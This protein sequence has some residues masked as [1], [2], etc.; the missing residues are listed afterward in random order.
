MNKSF[1][2]RI[3]LLSIGAMLAG[4]I[5]CKGPASLNTDKP[6]QNAQNPAGNGSGGT[7]NPSNPVIPKTDQEK[8]EAA[9]AALEL[10]STEKV[11]GW[12]NLPRNGRYDTSISWSA[13]PTGIIDTD[14][15]SSDR[16][17]IAQPEE[18]TQ[19]T[20]TA[21]ITKGSASA[22]KTFTVT[23]YGKYQELVDRAVQ[24]MQAPPAFVMGSGTPPK[25]IRLQ[26]IYHTGFGQ[27]DFEWKAEPEGIVSFS[28][29]T[30]HIIGTITQPESSAEKKTVTLTATAKKGSSTAV[31]T[32]T[33]TVYPKD[34]EPS[35]REL[36]DQ[37]MSTIP[38]ETEQSIPLPRTVAAGYGVNWT[39][40]DMNVLD[41]SKGDHNITRDLIDRQVTVKAELR[42]L[43]GT[44][45][46]ETAEKTVTVKAQTQF[47][48][49]E[50]AGNRL[51]LKDSNGT[52]TAVY[53]VDIHADTK[54][55]A[56]TAEQVA[57]DGMLMTLDAAKQ[58]QLAVIERMIQYYR[59]LLS[60]CD[61]QTVTLQ[62]IKEAEVQWDSAVAT[63]SD[64]D[65]FKRLFGPSMPYKD[66]VNKSPEEKAQFLKANYLNPTKEGVYRNMRIPLNT[67]LEQALTQAK[68]QEIA[69]ITARVEKAAQSRIYQYRV[70]SHNNTLNTEATYSTG[71]PWY[72]QNGGYYYSGSNSSNI[73]EVSLSS[74]V[75]GNST[76]DVSISIRKKGSYIY[77]SFYADYDGI[78]TIMAQTRKGKQI[79]V[80]VTDNGNGTVTVTSS[81]D[82]SFTK[83]LTFSGKSISSNPIWE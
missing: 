64:E 5:A 54:T 16:G 10:R 52:A 39:S 23:V 35:L 37:L 63:V 7:E 56:A 30:Q 4:I 62:D 32:F 12:I 31:R 50:I 13:S 41:T 49:C 67:P 60:L 19:V 66:F 75:K 65:L 1:F 70:D 8:V 29:D 17:R 2:Y 72:Q 51:T 24:N 61:K 82:V 6:K 44:A 58:Q 18:D 26:K 69:N 11:R 53:R 40:S 79:T 42:K 20:L 46:T 38:A 27:V 25:T 3:M 28:E 36:L 48:N 68:E 14:E 43:G 73:E 71:T 45:E 33:V 22:T 77:D 83:G 9:K 59:S 47:D 74:R 78:G 55:I 21:R 15:S 76:Y 81:G 34:A 80:T 57:V